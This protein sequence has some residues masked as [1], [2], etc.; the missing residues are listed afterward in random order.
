MHIMESELLPGCEV[1]QLDDSRLPLSFYLFCVCVCISNATIQCFYVYRLVSNIWL[2]MSNY[3]TDL[4]G[5]ADLT[6]D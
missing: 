3:Q 5:P 1:V 4:F 6:L 2:F